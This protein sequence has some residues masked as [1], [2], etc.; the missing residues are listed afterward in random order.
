MG[1]GRCSHCRDS[2]PEF[3]RAVSFGE[4]GDALR[5]LIRLLKYEQ[6]SPVAGPLGGMLAR[7]MMELMPMGQGNKPVLIPVPLH[8]SRRHA[9]GFNQSELIAQAA[10]RRLPQ[11]LEVLRGVLIRQRDTASQVGLSREERIKNVR[12]AF[13]VT[14]SGRVQGRDVLLV[15][16]VMTTGTTLSECARVLKQAGAKRVLAA[17]VARAFDSASQA[18]ANPGEEEGIGA[19]CSASI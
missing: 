9:R 6:V 3:E 10:A 7:A 13:R 1:D 17:T 15:D 4:Y 8:K 16:D 11:K 19:S 18:A 12:D 5:G 2:A 14:D